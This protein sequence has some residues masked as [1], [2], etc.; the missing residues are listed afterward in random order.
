MGSVPVFP[1]PE[2]PGKADAH[3]IVLFCLRKVSADYDEKDSKQN[4]CDGV[5]RN[6]GAHAGKQHGRD[7]NQCQDRN[8]PL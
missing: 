4:R 2:G 7:E 3:S 1:A 8:E 6:I 5:N